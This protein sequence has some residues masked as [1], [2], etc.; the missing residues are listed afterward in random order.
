MSKHRCWVVIHRLRVMIEGLCLDIS[1]LKINFKIVTSSDVIHKIIVL[2]LI[3]IRHAALNSSF[4]PLKL[5]FLF[6]STFGL[7]FDEQSSIEQRCHPPELVLVVLRHL[8]FLAWPIPLRNLFILIHHSLNS[9]MFLRLLCIFFSP[10]QV[11]LWA[12]QSSF[13]CRV[14]SVFFRQQNEF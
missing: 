13:P 9:V 10:V 11:L 2:K 7:V 6:H 14:R 5:S 3:I 12:P 4:E 8:I 1:L